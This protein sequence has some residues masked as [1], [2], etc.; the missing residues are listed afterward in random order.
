MRLTGVTF[1]CLLSLSFLFAGSSVAD[2]S[3]GAWGDMPLP[4]PPGPYVSSRSDIAD[5]GDQGDSNITMPFVGNMP[6]NPMRYMPGHQPMPS[7][8]RM[9]PGPMRRY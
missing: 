8:Y 7:P 1:S 6:S 3:A 9:W 5:N 2:E 4:P